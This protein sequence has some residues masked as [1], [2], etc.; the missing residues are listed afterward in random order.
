MKPPFKITSKIVNLCAG[1]SRVIG[2]CE[3]LKAF[4]PTPQLR[5]HNRI[6]T[7]HASLAIEG[8]SLSES[9]VTD[10][11]DNKK[12]LGPVQDILEVKNAVKV[13]DLIKQYD[14]SSLKSLLSAH[15]TLMKHIS[16]DAGKLRAGNV[17]VMKG[18]KIIHM[19]PKYTQVPRL[20]S[21]LLEFLKKEKD[22]HPFI[23][24][25][26]AHY[27]LEFIHPFSDGNGRMGRLWQSAILIND[28]PVFEFIP[29]ESL[30]KIKQKAYYKALSISDKKGE[31]TAFI[32]FM[33]TA[34]KE[35]IEEFIKD[36]RPVPQ[37]C[38]TRLISAAQHFGKVYFSRKK[39]MQFHK[40]ISP[41]TAS[42]DLLFGVKSTVLQK[43]GSRALTRYKFF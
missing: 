15:K 8:N 13:Y 33:L 12:V 11:I 6:K 36:I 38:K 4:P 17:V 31:S 21:N 42:R 30:I 22:V 34:I 1:I 24:S 27:E 9:Q 10:I 41:A 20:I 18:R 3:G 14:V 28:Y 23:K 16:T 37:T 25:S 32:E 5:R 43:A 19:S 7:I 2:Q 39:Y 26:V 40:D 35:A 29:V